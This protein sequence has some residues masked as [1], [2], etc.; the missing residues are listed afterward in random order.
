MGF[1]AGRG[2]GKNLQGRV[3]PIQVQKRQGKGAVG[4]Y[5]NEDPNRA[6]PVE[7]N[8]LFLIYF[9]IN[10]IVFIE[11]EHDESTGRS[12]KNAGPKVPQWRKQ[13]REVIS[14]IAYP[15]NNVFKILFFYLESP[16]TTLHL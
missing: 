15:I 4:H 5:G 9:K 16:Q 10:S 11:P 1:E 12:K 2:L 6:V 14:I 3:L 7:S 13:Q 8:Q